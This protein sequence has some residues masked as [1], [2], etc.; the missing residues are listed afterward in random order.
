M[1]KVSRVD[2]TCDQLPAELLIRPAIH[3]PIGTRLVVALIA[4]QR[5]Y[6]F[7][8]FGIQGRQLVRGISHS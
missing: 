5:A 4:I 2:A 3:L 1:D 8:I 7:D 6:E